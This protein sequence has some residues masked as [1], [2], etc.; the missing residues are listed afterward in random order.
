M[1]KVPVMIAWLK[2][3]EKNPKV[4]KRV[5][6]YDGSRDMSTVQSIRP[7]KTLVRGASYEVEE[8][9]HY[10]LNYSDNNATSLLFEALDAAEINDVLDNMDVNNNPYDGNN[11]I[12]VHSYSGFFRVL[13]N[14]AY[15]NREMSEKALYLLTLEDFP[16][17]IASGVPTG[18]TVAAKYG[19]QTSGSRGEEIQ[20]HEF[21]IIYHPK[22]P[23]ILGIMTSG[24]DLG[25]QAEVIRSISSM[26]YASAGSSISERDSRH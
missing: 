22:G 24:D 21:G 8:L 3:A 12:S 16:Q 19:E 17:G 26:V 6:T 9:L 1:M 4:L 20:L 11:H 25:K 10:M 15:L 7:R 18:I 23:Y 5:I 2:K 13:Y 14:A